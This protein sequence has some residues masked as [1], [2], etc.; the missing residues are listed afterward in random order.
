MES[1]NAASEKRSWLV[2]GAQLLRFA[3]DKKAG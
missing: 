3:R 1:E 2:E